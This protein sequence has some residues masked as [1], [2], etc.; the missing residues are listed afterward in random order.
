MF[1]GVQILSNTTKH[2]QTQSN[3]IKQHQTWCSNGKGRDTRCD[4]SLRPVAVF[5]SNSR[6]LEYAECGYF[7]L[8]F[9]IFCEQRQRNEQRIITHSY[10]AIVLVAVAVEVCSILNFLKL[11][12]RQN[13]EQSNELKTKSGSKKRQ[14]RVQ[15]TS[16]L[17][18]ETKTYKIAFLPFGLRA[19]TNYLATKHHK[20]CLVA[21]HFKAVTHHATN[22]CDPSRGE[23]LTEHVHIYWQDHGADLGGD[24]LFWCPVPITPGDLILKAYKIFPCTLLRKRQWCK[25]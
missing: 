25:I 11:N 8:L 24:T 12:K 3:T 4:K 5:N 18:N 2:D 23:E 21:K 13:N 15:K 20:H 9:V 22:R 1:D 6:S 10:T 7:T 17:W 19:W 14:L 16:L